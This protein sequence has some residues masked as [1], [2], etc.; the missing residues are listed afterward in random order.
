[1]YR[2]FSYMVNL[3]VGLNK[4]NIFF[5]QLED[6]TLKN[7]ESMRTELSKLNSVENVSFASHMPIQIYSNSW[8]FEWEGKDPDNDV[9]TKLLIEMKKVKARVIKPFIF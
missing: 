8:G 3:P 6:E 4:D 7:L 2:Q 1:M 9:L 5:F